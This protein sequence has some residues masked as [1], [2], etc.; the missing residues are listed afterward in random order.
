MGRTR[1]NIIVNESKEL[2]KSD[3]NG[4][5][6]TLRDMEKW[7]EDVFW[8]PFPLLSQVLIRSPKT[9]EIVPSINIFEDKGDIV[10]KVELPGVKK[11]DID[12][13]LTHNAITISGEKR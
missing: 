8:R 12:I 2:R 4:S 5:T 10:V 3:T 11:N 9:R 6:V 1:R 7:F 13:R